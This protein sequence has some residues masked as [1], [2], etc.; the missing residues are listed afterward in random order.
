MT[1][2]VRDGVVYVPD[3]LPPVNADRSTSGAGTAV[4]AAPGE[5]AYYVLDCVQ[6]E[7]R[8]AAAVTAIVKSGTRVLWERQMVAQ[9]DGL[10]LDKPLVCDANT[11]VYVDLSADVAVKVQMLVYK[12]QG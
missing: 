2:R 1:A 8:G 7:N 10:L 11:A 3:Y 4:L 9:G 6:L 5:G 12:V